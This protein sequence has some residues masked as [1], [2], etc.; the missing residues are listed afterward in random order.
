MTLRG[1]WHEDAQT[2]VLDGIRTVANLLA[3]KKIRIHK[4]CAK[5]LTELQNYS[6]DTKAGTFPYLCSIHPY[7]KGTITVTPKRNEK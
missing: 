5:L 7:M 1:V 6:W 2:E 4:R 3:K